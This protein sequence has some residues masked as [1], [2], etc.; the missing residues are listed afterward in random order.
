MATTEGAALGDWDMF[1]ERIAPELKKLDVARDSIDLVKAELFMAAISFVDNRRR[2]EE[3][4]TVGSL[5]REFADLAAL[6]TSRLGQRLTILSDFELAAFF[7]AM[8]GAAVELS[9]DGGG[10]H[11]RLLPETGDLA[12]AAFKTLTRLGDDGVRAS[13]LVYRRRT[14]TIADRIP[15]DAPVD[16]LARFIAGLVDI[17]VA[18]GDGD[19]RKQRRIRSIMNMLLTIGSLGSATVH[20]AITERFSFIPDLHG[21]AALVEEIAPLCLEDAKTAGIPAHALATAVFHGFLK[22]S[23]ASERRAVLTLFARVFPE[24]FARFASFLAARF[25]IQYRLQDA[26]RG[27]RRD[28]G[29]WNGAHAGWKLIDEV[30]ET[31]WPDAGKKLNF[32]QRDAVFA[33]VEAIMEFVDGGRR[34]QTKAAK[35]RRLVDGVLETDNVANVAN[36][37]VNREHI[38]MLAALRSAIHKL[39]VVLG[40]LNRGALFELEPISCTNPDART[41][42]E[43]L[44]RTIAAL[45]LWRRKLD[46]KRDLGQYERA[47]SAEPNATGTRIALPRMPQ[48]KAEGLAEDEV[49]IGKIVAAARTLMPHVPDRPPLNSS[50]R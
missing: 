17:V 50:S 41:E 12:T 16:K 38:T 5:E 35:R 7:G 33:I 4:R 43:E 44:R 8:P 30:L 42:P 48:V 10:D 24:A 34:D 29:R 36:V 45:Q 3:A 39:D 37:S 47:T 26:A 14:E 23:P 46:E 9:I 31:V 15:A 40:V 20:K 22:H 18:G 28:A 27:A 49:A 21:K 6:P 2:D 1:C 13:G 32:R 11:R 25:E 19:D